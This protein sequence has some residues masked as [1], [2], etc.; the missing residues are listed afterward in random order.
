VK[1]RV[2]LAVLT[3]MFL[4]SL[5]SVASAAQITKI[6][7]G[8]DPAIYGTKVTWS[9]NSGSVHVYDLTTKK[10][11]KISSS[12]S[13][14]PVIYENKIVWLD[15]SSGA[16]KLTVY[17]I[18]TAGRSYIT[19]NIGSRSI[20]AIYG[21]R[22]V[23]N[24]NH[25]VYMRDISKSTQTW[26]AE[27]YSQDIYDTKL[28][29]SANSRDMADIF[30]YDIT[31]KKTTLISPYSGSID[32]PHMYGNKVIWVNSRSGTG[33]ID[34]YD[35]V[36]KKTTE[37]TSDHTG[38]TLNG[39]EDLDAGCDT[40]FHIDI[41][42]NKLVY[43]KSGNDQFGTAGVYVYDILSA[44]S[45]LVYN[46]PKDTDTT[47][48]IYGSTVVW[49]IDSDS[50][51]GIS[52]TGIYV[53][54]L[55]SKPTVD[56]SANKVSGKAPLSVQ[57]TSKTTGNPT[58]YYWIFEPSTSSDWNSHHAVTATHTFKKPGTYTISLTVTN[59]AGNTT[60]TKKNFITVK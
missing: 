27:G 59:G 47:P 13:S 38:N 26:I 3:S 6:G 30:S 25:T 50:S 45:T 14:H 44:K 8:R 21:N 11:T 18:K 28:V 58:D 19:K 56:I 9:D 32:N 17:N 60:V 33:Y 39:S 15:E 40:G 54:N 55:E 2:V 41:N 7:E 57:F 51:N 35:I 31:T 53:C 29:Y 16:P 4:I 46:Y 42:G 1:N 10:D 24:T 5:V 22:I 23:W 49:G 12:S 43:S 20:P 34:M 48:D 37:V 52:D 36:T